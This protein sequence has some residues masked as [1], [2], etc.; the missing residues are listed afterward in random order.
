[1]LLPLLLFLQA[2]VLPSVSNLNPN[3]FFILVL[4]SRF[5][6][7]YAGQQ[8]PA[9]QTRKIPN[10]TRNKSTSE[11]ATKN[12]MELQEAKRVQHSLRWKEDE[13]REFVAVSR[14]LK[15]RF[16]VIL[17]GRDR[18][19]WIWRNDSDLHDFEGE[20]MVIEVFFFPMIFFAC[21]TVQV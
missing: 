16:L 9:N 4:Q 17:G 19:S 3:E 2:A 5:R 11:T 20:K 1:M 7:Q 18:V 13:V 14:K 21:F 15:I 12:M 10:R 8:Q 6:V